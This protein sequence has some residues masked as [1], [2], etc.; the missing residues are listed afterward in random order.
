MNFT[1]KFNPMRKNVLILFIL[2]YPFNLT[3]AQNWETFGG[4]SSRSGQSRGTGPGQAST[5]LWQIQSGI[6]ASLGMAVYSFGDLFVNSRTNFSPYTSRIECRNLNNGSLNWVSPFLSSSSILYAIG[7][8]EDAV[9]AHDYQNDSLYALRLSDGSIKWRS[10]VLSQT[11]GAWPGCVFA[12]NGDPIVNG[13]SASGKFTM[14]IDKNTGDTLWTNSELIVIGP[15][16]ALAANSDKVY[17]I[18]GGIT[19]PIRLTAIDIKTGQTLYSSASIPGDPDQEDPMI[20]GPDNLIIFWRDGGNLFAY[21]DNGNGFTQE[22]VYMPS[23]TVSV[24][25]LRNLCMGPGNSLYFFENNKVKRLDALTGVLIDS[26]Q[27]NIGSSASM[28]TGN[29]SILYINNGSGTCYAYTADLSTLKWQRSIPGSVYS[30]PGL[31]REGTLILTQSGL[32]ITA[33]RDPQPALAPVADFRCSARRVNAGQSV[34]FF[35]QS[36]F[37]PNAWLWQFTGSV[38]GSSSLQNPTGIVYT[39]PGIYEVKLKAQN[40]SGADSVTKSCYLEVLQSTTV[41]EAGMI[42][43]RVFPNPAHHFIQARLP[44][45]LAGVTFDLID[46]EGQ[47][48][49]TGVFQGDGTSWDIR[50]LPAGIFLIRFRQ[51]GIPTLRFVKE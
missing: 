50:N 32:F 13:P 4:S 25:L 23:G 51:Y 45:S 18:T 29:D 43:L 15:P 48:V 6:S 21:R 49:S 47:L 39:A 10:S 7:M 38:Q 9:Y 3:I 16:V 46:A 12:C 41:P 40:A 5:P 35:D 14:R 17:R 22:W 44:E 37:S 28:T 36:S 20:L 30:N 1:P 27:L 24:P 26:T 31:S 11:F 2:L 33:F 19:L 42:S 8:T 34:D